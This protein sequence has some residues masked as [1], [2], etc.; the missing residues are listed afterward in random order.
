M[1]GRQIR[2]FL[3]SL[4]ILVSVLFV[5]CDQPDDVVAPVSATKIY[6]SPVQ[7]PSTPSGFIYEFWAKDTAG[8]AYSIGKFQWDSYLY[9]FLDGNSNK[10][11]S[12]WTVDY[13]VLNSFYRFLEVSVEPYPDPQPDVQGAIILRD[14]IGDPTVNPIQMVYPVDFGIS[15]VGFSLET[16]TDKNSESYDASGVWFALYNYD[17]LV[18]SDT[19]RVTMSTSTKEPRRL[20]LD[21]TY[22]IC[23]EEDAGIC[24]DSSD[25][26]PQVL[27]DPNYMIDDRWRTLDTTNLLEL[28]NTLDTLAI[29]CI[30][31]VIDSFYVPDSLA[32]D[33]FIHTTLD[34]DFVARPVN[35]GTKTDTV[36]MVDPCSGVSRN[37]IIEPFT[38]YIHSLTYTTVTRI[39][40]IDRFL[41]NYEEVPDLTGTKWHY[42]GWIISPYLPADCDELGR[43]TKPQWTDFIIN[44]IFERPDDWAII[45][46]GSFKSFA[47][48]DDGNPY[49]LKRRVPNFPG[50]DFLTNLPCGRAVPYIFAD[51]T[52]PRFET[53]D[54]FI[55]LEPDDFDRNTNFPLFLFTTRWHIPPYELVSDTST[56]H[57]QTTS[58]LNVSGRVT[59]NPFGFPG[60]DVVIERK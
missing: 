53:G 47:T 49:S 57:V 54:I 27:L 14:T 38:D 52:Q 40:K 26:T 35:I 46:T 51:S 42:K 50:E 8:T 56:N 6:L 5:G 17:S 41:P 23:N 33:T 31:T 25:I 28:A 48:H 7:L 58:M 43:M 16:P 20:E 1:L 18:I 9:R 13:D 55:T 3:T 44:Q 30:D 4:M 60:I 2:L 29:V 11:D 36:P 37:L 22:W 15:T 34:F 19:V 59:N 12:F 45:S 24:I 32:I 10:I 21:T 39:A